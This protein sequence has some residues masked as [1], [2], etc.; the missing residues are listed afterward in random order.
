MEETM[1]Q[2]TWPASMA[3]EDR[4]QVSERVKRWAQRLPNEWKSGENYLI[5]E[6]YEGTKEEWVRTLP[7]EGFAKMFAEPILQ[8]DVTTEKFVEISRRLE[9]GLEEDVVKGNGVFQYLNKL[10]E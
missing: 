3:E 7:I 1:E 10:Q 6:K 4:H 9:Y 8:C 2:I 5:I